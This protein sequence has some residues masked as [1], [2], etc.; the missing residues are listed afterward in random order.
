M[1]LF[2]K[3]ALRNL[4]RNRT[5]TILNLIMIIGAFTAIIVFRGFAH[6]M[7]NS[8]E[9][10]LTESQNGHVQIATPQVWNSD[11]PKDKESAYLS[12]H[13]T[14]EKNL[15]VL[16]SVRT[17]S[18][19]ANAYV[20]LVNG[21]K[22]IAAQALGFNPEKEPGIVKWLKFVEGSTFST[23]STGKYE[24]LVTTGLQKNLKLAVGQTVS[25]VSQTLAGSMSSLDLE[26]KGIVS[27]GISDID[28]STVYI[29]LNV[30]Q[31]LLG[32]NRVERV[33]I[34]LNPDAS[35]QDSLLEIKSKIL[36]EPTLIAKSWKDA[37]ALFRQ[38]VDFYAVQNLLV[39]IILAS[40]V[41]FGI[42]NTLG[43]SI[44]ERIGELGTLRALGD[45]AETVL[46]QLVLEGLLLGIIG[47][48]IA[49]PISFLI[50]YGVSSLEVQILMPGASR[51]MAVHVDPIT[52][53][54]I[55]SS[56]VVIS[57]CVIAS[58]WPAQKAMRLTIVE[59]LRANS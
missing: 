27:S 17:V 54:Y 18:G 38:L 37:V 2:F 34:L 43:M 24:I 5:R 25:V 21:D 30:M 44:Y 6:Y 12:Q 31:K 29:P 36:S 4:V 28:N 50:A 55:L 45:R 26:V 32:T 15:A 13:E 51:E 47:A 22:S 11:L 9:I 48:L 52:Y 14:L 46:F 53:D 40:L 42:L 59:A 3:L 56:L 33:A 49:V 19:R 10:S 35:L 23:G 39:E 8:I 58:F 57:T 1:S 41:F 16:P 20:L 7:L